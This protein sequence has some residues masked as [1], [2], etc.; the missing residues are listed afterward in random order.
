MLLRVLPPAAVNA[1]ANAGLRFLARLWVVSRQL[2]HELTGT[3]FL[4]LGAAA[5]PTL[6]REWRGRSLG[7]ALAVAGFLALM[8][9]FGVTSFRRARRIHKV[10]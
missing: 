10:R 6:I 4:A 1:L 3:L 8:L 9:Y 2:W 7:R 5:I